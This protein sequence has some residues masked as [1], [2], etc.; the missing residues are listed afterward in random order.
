VAVCSIVTAD[1]KASHATTDGATEEVADGTTKEYDGSTSDSDDEFPAKFS[2]LE[3]LFSDLSTDHGR[4]D[5]FQ[6]VS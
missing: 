4:L 3:L 5:L 6:K 1:N 2:Q